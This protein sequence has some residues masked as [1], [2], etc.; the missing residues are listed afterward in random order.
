MFTIFSELNYIAI[1]MGSR[2]RRES[3]P[4]F[5]ARMSK[6]K[7]RKWRREVHFFPGEIGVSGRE[8][9]EMMLC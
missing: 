3:L 9:K 7:S 4:S 6:Y 2:E 8:E 5:L 1:I